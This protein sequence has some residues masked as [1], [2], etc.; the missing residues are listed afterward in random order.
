MSDKYQLTKETKE[1]SDRRLRRIRAIRDI[2]AYARSGQLGG[3]IE[4]AKN[5]S[6]SGNARMA[7]RNKFWPTRRCWV[8]HSFW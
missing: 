8:T 6:E 4:T 7:V 3:W 2:G 1:V 5:L